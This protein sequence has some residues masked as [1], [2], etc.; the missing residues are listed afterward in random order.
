VS[1]N[2]TPLAAQVDAMRSDL[3]TLAEQVLSLA[4][5]QSVLASKM[6]DLIEFL[7]GGCA[8]KNCKEV[9]H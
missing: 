8:C 9:S 2:G 7:D 3:N 4:R 1:D 5:Q 6:S